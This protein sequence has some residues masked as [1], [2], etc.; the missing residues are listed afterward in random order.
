MFIKTTVYRYNV[1]V[2]VGRFRCSKSIIILNSYMYSRFAFLF[3]FFGIAA[4][5]ITTVLHWRYK[6][7]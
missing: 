4:L 3:F 7:I 2:D 5:C 6:V 1:K